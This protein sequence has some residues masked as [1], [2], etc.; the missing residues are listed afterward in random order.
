[1][2]LGLVYEDYHNR[3]RA[4]ESYNSITREMGNNMKGELV[5][6]LSKERF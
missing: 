6:K 5:I 1:M 3:N 4:R 2:G